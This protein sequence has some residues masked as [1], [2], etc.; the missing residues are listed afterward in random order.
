MSRDII[1]CAPGRLGCMYGGKGD[2][3]VDPGD[4]F[5]YHYNN[6]E[7]IDEKHWRLR[8]EFRFKKYQGGCIVRTW[9]RT[10]YDGFLPVGHLTT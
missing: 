1:R 8:R 10:G 5:E 2:R 6:L 4:Q 9:R 7:R 3:N